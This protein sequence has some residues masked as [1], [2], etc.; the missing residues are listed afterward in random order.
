MKKIRNA[1]SVFY[2]A[3]ILNILIF[4][5]EISERHLA[6]KLLKLHVRDTK[7][8]LQFTLYS[9]GIEVWTHNYH[10]HKNK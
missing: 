10:F 5:L 2:F 8:C 6:L 3:F 7:F 9:S 4:F 1:K